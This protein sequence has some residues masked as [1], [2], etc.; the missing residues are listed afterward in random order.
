MPS[1]RLETAHRRS[2]GLSVPWYPA[3]EEKLAARDS[4]TAE[5]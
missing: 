2:Q 1:Q 5:A 4:A 3:S